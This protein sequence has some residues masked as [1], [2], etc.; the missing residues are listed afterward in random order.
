MK[1]S[2]FILILFSTFF[3]YSQK[4]Y[5]Y[6]QKENQHEITLNAFNLIAAKWVD[7]SY[8]RILNEESSVGVS[9]L[10]RVGNHTDFE[11]WGLK[12]YSVTPYYRQ[13]FSPYHAAG[14]FMEA[15]AMYNGGE[16]DDWVYNEITNQ[17]EKQQYKDVAF[18]ISIGQK[19]V[20]R[21]GFVGAVYAGLGRNMF[22]VNAPEVVGRAGVSFGFRF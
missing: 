21:R 1:K 4:R 6:V 7:V 20:T 2:L 8:E 13:Y 5:V 12:S 17:K 3:S 19:F 14:F 18:G 10:T 22:D 16:R 9:F 15:F 11:D